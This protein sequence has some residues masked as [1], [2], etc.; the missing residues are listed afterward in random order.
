M[1]IKEKNT[2]T[3]SYLYH[4][5]IIKNYLTK[6]NYYN[7]LI[8]KI[9]TSTRSS[10]APTSSSTLTLTTSSST[11]TLTTSSSTLTLTTSSSIFKKLNYP[12]D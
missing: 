3:L 10:P 8:N 4:Y 11:L 2:K 5:F 12:S 6:N 1:N 7:K 9:S